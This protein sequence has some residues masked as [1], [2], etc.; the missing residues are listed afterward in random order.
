[1]LCCIVFLCC[2]VLC[3]IVL[4]CI[5]L[6]C[7]SLYCIVLYCVVLWS[8]GPSYNT[9][10]VHIICPATRNSADLLSNQEGVFRQFY[11]SKHEFHN[12][13]PASDAVHGLH[14]DVL[15]CHTVRGFQGTRMNVISFTPLQKARF[16]LRRFSRHSQMVDGTL[17]RLLVLNFPQV[18]RQM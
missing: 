9:K 12:N 8:D 13:E 3:F 14:Q 5:V 2:I 18:G 1:M 6:C 4:C 16:S 15:N 10:T 11:V 17:C 7:V